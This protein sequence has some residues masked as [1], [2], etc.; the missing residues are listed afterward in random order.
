[1]SWLSV[2]LKEQ[3]FYAYK[4][5][6]LVRVVPCSTGKRGNT[7]PGRFRLQWKVRKQTMR[8]RQGEFRVENV[9]W[10][11]YYDRDHGIAIHTAYW[12]QNFGQPVSHGCINLP[13]EDA[14]WVYEW[15]HPLVLPEDSETF[16]VPG[17]P[18]SRV[19]VF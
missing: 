7:A 11:M 19:V 5:E 4:G 14:R 18:G 13:H 10:V 12:H 17:E 3:L 16:P 8:L 6:Q 1:M 9:D 2:D 15:S